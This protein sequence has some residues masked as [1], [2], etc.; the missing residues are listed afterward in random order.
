MPK[1][2][3]CSGTKKHFRSKK[4]NSIFP[5][6]VSINKIHFIKHQLQTH[7]LLSNNWTITSCSTSSKIKLCKL[8][9]NNDIIE[10]FY[11]VT[12]NE[13]FSYTVTSF[14]HSI[15]L[16]SIKTI[17]NLKTLISLINTLDNLQICQG[18]SD[19]K[20]IEI[21]TRRNDK[22][23]DHQ[24]KN[25]YYF[26]IFYT[27]IHAGATVAFLEQT[28]VK[29]IRHKDCPFLTDTTNRCISCN[30]YRKTLFALT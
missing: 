10:V 21:S 14:G 19:T 12:I 22:F 18:N 4:R 3:F 9:E 8:H 7:H 15:A 2:Y 26:V 17:K 29:T 28:P 20:F 1:K 13:D 24:G 11:S 16:E 27:V 5:L 30:N 6:T 23:T 25:N